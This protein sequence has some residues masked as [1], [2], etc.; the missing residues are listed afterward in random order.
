MTAQMG[1][2]K[3]GT[4]IVLTASCF[5]P[6]DEIDCSSFGYRTSVLCTEPSHSDRCKALRKKLGDTNA[7]MVKNE[8]GTELF[9]I[10]CPNEAD[11]EFLIKK[12]I[13]PNEE[14]IPR[15]EE[16]AQRKP[17]NR[18]PELKACRLTTIM[19]ALILCAHS[20]CNVQGEIEISLQ[21]LEIGP[22]NFE[23]ANGLTNNFHYIVD[24]SMLARGCKHT[25]TVS[26]RIAP[27]A[28]LESRPPSKGRP[29]RR[30][31]SVEQDD[32]IASDGDDDFQ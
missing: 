8:S 7:L 17:A 1:E 25:A 3:A 32:P 14:F 11:G 30:V 6:I 18:D 26:R 15:E 29:R 2:A 12:S 24:Q 31:S 4:V 10:V 27:A 20:D 9:A 19:L 16:I 13:V 21:S 23:L 5:I 22:L 28:G